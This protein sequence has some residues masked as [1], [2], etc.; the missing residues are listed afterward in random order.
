MAALAAAVAVMLAGVVTPAR[1]QM[2]PPT[3]FA[4]NRFAGEVGAVL[5]APSSPDMFTLQ[6]GYL[7]MDFRVGPR[8][9]FVPRSAE[10]QVEGFVQGDFAV[11]VGHRTKQGWLAIRIFFDVQPIR[12]LREIIGT[13]MR[14]SPNGA[15][16]LIR[17][18]TGGS[19]FARTN[20]QTRFRVDGRL[21]DGQPSLL[22][23]EIVQAL[24]LQRNGWI[25][26]EVNVRAAG[27]LRNVR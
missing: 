4:D 7:A 15:R 1:A 26:Y 10:A 20:R 17:L 18:D 19:L 21:M 8:T 25:A 5:G 23:G 13:I 16:F 11:V 22:R 2:I 24:V 3:G 27:Y 9:T 6:L 14:V 12:P